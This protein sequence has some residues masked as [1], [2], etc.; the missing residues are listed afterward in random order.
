MSGHSHEF[1]SEEDTMEVRDN[2]QIE[3]EEEGSPDALRRASS[4]ITP[5]A[6]EEDPLEDID[7]RAIVCSGAPSA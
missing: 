2:S 1:I 5:L 4:P 3:Y 6:D 7:I